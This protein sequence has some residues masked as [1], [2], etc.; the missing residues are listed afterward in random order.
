MGGKGSDIPHDL[1]TCLTVI[2]EGLKVT[3]DGTA[4]A[5]NAKQRKILELTL[6]NT[7]R[8]SRLIDKILT[9]ERHGRI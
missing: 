5:I 2:K 6:K 1:Y 8:L 7:L 4:G 9:G 3:L